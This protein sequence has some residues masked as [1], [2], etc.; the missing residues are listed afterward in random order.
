MHTVVVVGAD[1][2]VDDVRVALEAEGAQVTVVPH[3]T[4]QALAAAGTSHAHALLA[5]D[6]SDSVNLAAALDAREL[7]PSIRLVIRQFNRALAPKIEQNLRDCSVL[8]LSSHSAA[9]YAAAAIDPSCF[10]GLEF[11]AGSHSLVGFSRRGGGADAAAG[12]TLARS[13]DE[14]VVFGTITEIGAAAAPLARRR[15]GFR[16]VAARIAMIANEFDP[17]LRVLVLG[18]AAVFVAAT[19]FFAYS[20]KLNPFTA[21]YFVTTTMTTTG[22][23]DIGLADKALYLQGVDMLLMVSGVLVANLAMAFI[24]AALV[25]AQYTG[26]QGLRPIRD[27][28]HVVVFGAGRVGTRVVDLL[29]ELGALVTVV[30]L[31][32]QSHLLRKARSRHINLLT[33]DGAHDQT[34]D[35]SNVRSARC[36]VVLTDADMTNLEIGLGA[37]ARDPEIPLIMRIAEPRLAT[38]I[39]DQFGI[40][41]TFSAT[42]LASSAFADLAFSATARGRVSFAGTT[43]RLAETSAENADRTANP[44]A[45]SRPGDEPMTVASWDDVRPGDVVL[46][47]R[48]VAG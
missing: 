20:L 44:L 35:F 26:L 5:L 27:E 29:C 22:Y 9:T 7:N 31:Q 8:S 6:E 28:G 16:W 41:R 10:L 13:G 30:E 15:R 3:P 45:V 12:R 32:P 48:E 36:A 17:L 37:R 47:M 46:T 42:A 11:P 43:Y 40:R 39:R 21:A 38:S 24:A 14:T 33:G 1:D 25:R 19:C 18:G 34:L 23:G 4:P 2:L